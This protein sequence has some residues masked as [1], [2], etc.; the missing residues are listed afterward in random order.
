MR[1][2]QHYLVGWLYRYPSCDPEFPGA[3]LNGSIAPIGSPKAEGARLEGIIYASTFILWKSGKLQATAKRFKRS[4]HWP[5][6][7]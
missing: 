6:G 1:H 3:A 5:A 4:P 2:E 7:R